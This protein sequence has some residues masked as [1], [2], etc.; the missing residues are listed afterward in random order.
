MV[1]G[2]AYTRAR[3]M[4]ARVSRPSV[5]RWVSRGPHYIASPS[6]RMRARRRNR[7]TPDN[8]EKGTPDNGS[9]A[10]LVKRTP[11]RLRTGAASLNEVSRCVIERLLFGLQRRFCLVFTKSDTVP[12]IAVPLGPRAP[13][14]VVMPPA[15]FPRFPMSPCS[16][17][18]P[19]A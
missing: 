3:A 7:E 10:L 18:S 5:R 12:K 15:V 16:L 2:P 8:S 1:R 14:A 11:S 13:F 9:S 6:A 19:N 4:W 17:A